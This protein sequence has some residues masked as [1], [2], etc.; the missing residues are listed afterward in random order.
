MDN[1]DKA[2]IQA[3]KQDARQSVSSIA[4]QVNLSRTSVS[5]RIKALE[6]SNVI[7]GYQV[8]LSESQKS[9]VSAYFEIQNTSKSCYEVLEM[10]HAI[11]EVIT[12][13]S[14]TGEMDLLVY[15]KAESMQRIH[16][17]REDIDSHHAV[18]KIKTHVVM[19]EWINN[20]ATN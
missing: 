6:K 7:R 3:L 14:I 8:M 19:S 17:I 5:A 1:F 18:L 10:I 20:N 13:H 12:C 2:I 4:E 15:I 16:Q 9:V 11:P